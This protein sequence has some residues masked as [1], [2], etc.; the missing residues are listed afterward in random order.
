MKIN[1][2]VTEFL[3]R[4]ALKEAKKAFFKNEVPVGAVIAYQEKIIARAHNK[5]EN[6]KKVTQHAEILV[7]EK[8]SRKLQDWRLQDCILCVTLEPCTMCM[9]AIKLAR[10]PT[11]II[12]AGD[13]E[14]GACGTLFDLSLDKRL[15]TVQKVISG[16]LK[17]E[18]S[19]ILKEFFRG[20]R[21]N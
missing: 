7:I 1:P 12:G 16:V 6:N 9:G 8:A 10:I 4:E 3:M 21:N 17:E 20:K 18:C 11:L 19:G 15:G 2:Q 5:V 14:K 13:S